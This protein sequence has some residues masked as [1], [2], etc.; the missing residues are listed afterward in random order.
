MNPNRSRHRKSRLK[1]VQF[2]WRH[3]LRRLSLMGLMGFALS[4][5]E[6]QLNLQGVEREQAKTI[7][8]FDMFQSVA[9]HGDRVVVV[10]STGAV[11]RSDDN[12]ANWERFD[13]SGRPSLIDV[14]SCPSGDFYALD[15]QH[16]IWRLLSGSDEWIMSLLDT[17]ESTLSIH[18]APDNTVW[19]TASFSTLYSSRDNAASW[20]EFTLDEDLQFTK[21]RF[22][23]DQVGIA[24]GEFGTVL[25]TSDG[26]TNWER[27]GDIP[28][29]YYPMAAHF[30]DQQTGWVGGLD[31]VIW[32]TTDGAQTWQRQQSANKAPIYG[33]D[34]TDERVFA[35]GGSGTLVEYVDGE[36]QL[37]AGAPPVLSYLRGLNILSN[38]SLLVAG[39]A[40][41]V[42][43]IPL[44][45][46][47]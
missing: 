44:P 7:T 19:V 32:A 29:E 26:G 35:V 28:N 47:S 31:G 27:G 15:T 18:C 14:S 10:S 33:I 46:D 34:A 1:P 36:W 17:R 30:R 21:I 16:Q 12:G 43:T 37:L 11:L 22:F 8:R 38:Q 41:T 20:Q 40:G 24:V 2:A 13:L 4:A 23:D 45:H 3:C 39:G 5:C 9:H 25:I 6:A 42:A